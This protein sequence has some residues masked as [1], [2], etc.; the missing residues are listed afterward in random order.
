MSEEIK[1]KLDHVL[2][3]LKEELS[4][5]PQG[6]ATEIPVAQRLFPETEP[7]RIQVVLL[8][9]EEDKVAFRR[10]SDL[11]QEER[12]S[13]WYVGELDEVIDDALSWEVEL[14][15]AEG[16]IEENLNEDFEQ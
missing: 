12:K 2:E 16:L 15:E 10:I 5:K 6:F 8:D 9:P 13:D 4:D 1:Q 7:P 14:E 3:E 11:L